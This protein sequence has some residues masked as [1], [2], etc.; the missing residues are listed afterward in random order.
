MTLS[1]VQ[2][3]ELSKEKEKNRLDKKIIAEKLE[4]T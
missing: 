2:K 1:M 4:Q 3:H